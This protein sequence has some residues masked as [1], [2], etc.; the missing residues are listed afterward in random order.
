[1]IKKIE[2]LGFLFGSRLLPSIL[3]LSGMPE[4]K[5]KQVTGHGSLATGIMLGA[6]A[7][8]VVTSVALSVLSGGT[9][10]APTLMGTAIL[11]G[12]IGA[13][14]GTVGWGL[15]RAGEH[16]LGYP[17]TTGIRKLV[18]SF[19]GNLLKKGAPKIKV[20]VEVPKA[21]FTAVPPRE[22]PANGL[23]RAVR[24]LTSSFKSAAGRAVPEAS[25]KPALQPA[26]AAPRFA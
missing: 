19:T 25:Q 17:V 24:S 1:M 4:D 6:G 21:S 18:T 11:H 2:E 10:I 20:T 22:R 5:V 23:L 13:L 14:A 9:L 8:L 12:S 3:I 16:Q 15:L 26:F 7:A